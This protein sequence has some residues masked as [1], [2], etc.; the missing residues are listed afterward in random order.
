[1]AAVVAAAWGYLLVV[2]PMLSS[3]G[4]GSVGVTHP[5]LDYAVIAVKDEMTDS[6]GSGEYTFTARKNS[7]EVKVTPGAHEGII[8]EVNGHDARWLVFYAE[9]SGYAVMCL[10]GS[11]ET[12]TPGCELYI[13]SEKPPAEGLAPARELTDEEKR[14]VWSAATEYQRSIKYNDPNRLRKLDETEKVIAERFKLREEDVA[15]VLAEGR[16]DDWPKPE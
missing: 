4:G 11:A 3:S 9:S 6:T 10:N 1:V 2:R 8:V 5:D 16:R 12:L 14:E 15:A 13:V 7:G